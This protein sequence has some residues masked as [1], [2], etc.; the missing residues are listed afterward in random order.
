MSR[1]FV[2]TD[3][4]R[5]QLEFWSAYDREGVAGYMYCEDYD[6]NAFIAEQ[7]AHFTALL[8]N[9]LEEDKE[10]VSFEDLCHELEG[11][12]F[13]YVLKLQCPH[14]NLFFSEV[15]YVLEDGFCPFC[16]ERMID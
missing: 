6:K 9:M 3:E 12:E 4:L 7:V 14:C 16:D 1:Y 11:Q 5:E 10:Y 8:L 2:N 13:E 15:D